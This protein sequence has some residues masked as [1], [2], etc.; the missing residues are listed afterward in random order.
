MYYGDNVFK[1]ARKWIRDK[2]SGLAEDKFNLY[3]EIRRD[4]DISLSGKDYCISLVAEGTSMLRCNISLFEPFR[5]FLLLNILEIFSWNFWSFSLFQMAFF[6]LAIFKP[7]PLNIL[8]L[9]LFLGQFIGG[10]RVERQLAM[11][12][13][14][15][16]C[17]ITLP[18]SST[19]LHNATRRLLSYK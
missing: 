5:A 19:V 8:R 16:V 18:M 2:T 12:K 3:W 9:F 6:F 14:V 11:F 7:F 13:P 10:I 17:N 1:K 15:S 4:G